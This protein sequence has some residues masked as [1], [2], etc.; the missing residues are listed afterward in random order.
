MIT[1]IDEYRIKHSVLEDSD[2]MKLT[3][4]TYGV[5]AQF[6]FEPRK[7]SHNYVKQYRRVLQHYYG[8]LQRQGIEVVVELFEPE[9]EK[10][11]RLCELLGMDYLVV[12][13]LEEYVILGKIL[14]PARVVEN[15]NE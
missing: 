9:S 13:G 11:I 7:W 3:C 10:K 8:V 1:Y 14:E 12:E 2:R 5:V 6:H 4:E 15:V